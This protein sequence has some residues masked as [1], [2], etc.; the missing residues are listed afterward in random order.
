MRVLAILL[1]CPLLGV[2]QFTQQVT[3]SKPLRIEIHRADVEL[4]GHSASNISI[5]VFQD[6]EQ[7]IEDPRASGLRV[8][9]KYDD[10]TGVGFYLGEDETGWILAKVSKRRLR[11]HIK[12]P[13]NMDVDLK[14]FRWDHGALSAKDLD[15]RLRL[16]VNN[17][18]M[19]LENL[20][21]L[22]KAET[23]S[24][25][26]KAVGLTDGFTVKSTSGD[27][28]VS[29]DSRGYNLDV[30]TIS[31]IIE[32]D[33]P[34]HKTKVYKGSTMH[35]VGRIRRF[36]QPLNGGGAATRIE[37]VSGSVKLKVKNS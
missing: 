27:V 18:H 29:L 23:T 24:G 17:M 3:P 2:A 5:E 14:E 1:L 30:R 36:K 10:N 11:A 15:G 37:S 7:K 4:V 21:A 32:A 25:D 12:V 22:V 13:K 31:G 16:Q 35:Q 26:I 20:S 8:I 9:S 34:I 6:S 33:F 28:Q 19:T